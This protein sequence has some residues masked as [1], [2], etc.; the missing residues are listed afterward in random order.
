MGRV[1]AR[2]WRAMPEVMVVGF[3]DSDPSRA[4][5]F[6]AEQGVT[7]FSSLEELIAAVDI[8]DVCSP[9]PT[10]ADYAVASLEAGRHCVCE[11][12]LARTLTDCDRV[13]AAAKASGKT[14]M[15][16]QVVRF[17]PE[18][19]AA[20]DQIAS[21][22]I[23]K[24]AVI[25]THRGGGFPRGINN[26]FADFAQSGGVTLDVIIHDFDW[27]RWTFGDVERVYAKTRFT[28]GIH[29]EDYALVTLR[30]SSGAIAHIEG[31]WMDASGFFVSIEAAGDKGLLQFDSRESAPIKASRRPVGSQSV[32]GVAYPESP[33]L[34]DPY[35]LEL[36]HFV[37]ALTAGVLPDITPEDG[38]AA[39]AIG[40]AALE[41]SRTG[42]PVSID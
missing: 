27:L 33:T 22:V 20:H 42:Q 2:A 34:L 11:K 21:G 23:G 19:R 38:R 13:V 37:D 5:T 12:P 25:R 1:H 4:A 39:V 8:V 6:A 29:E 40:L 32:G 15:P 9:T 36:R 30:F 7:A 24:P 10:H 14:L 3:Y 31:S 18:F 26:W 16:A 17:F 28:E 41:S 35:F